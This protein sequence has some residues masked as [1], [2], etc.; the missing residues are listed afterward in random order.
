MA[1]IEPVSAR[2]EAGPGAV[3]AYDAVGSGMPL[4]AFHGAYS[5][6][7]EVRGFLEPMVSGRSIRRIYVDLPGHGESRPSDALRTPDDAL[8]LVD[9]LL[10]AEAPQGPFLVAGHSFGAHFARALAARHPERV[11]GAALI[12]PVMAGEWETP[13][14]TVVQ[15]EGVSAQ[16][17]AQRA[18]YESYFVVRNADT[19]QRFRD[20]VV[21]ASG[22][23]D[24]QTLER[25]IAVAPLAIDPDTVT[26]DAPVLVTVGREDSVV[27]WRRQH[28]E[29]ADRYP[30]ATLAVVA[31]AGHALPH[32]R[33]ELLTA[34]V[35][36]WLDRV[37]IQGGAG[38]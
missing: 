14:F 28:R 2:I 32:E 38:S 27:G 25:A 22:D 33:P 31:G 23:V 29:L 30:R 7:A 34:L 20:A 21:P 18:E 5:G 24:E 1:P 16:L 13:P 12:C 9:A 4:L 6:R 36:D 19:L 37:G 26:L 17:E 10:A 35:H 8:D 11:A 3:L 15:D